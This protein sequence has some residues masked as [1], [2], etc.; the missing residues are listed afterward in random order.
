MFLQPCH[1]AF[2]VENVIA[3]QFIIDGNTGGRQHWRITSILGPCNCFIGRILIEADGAFEFLRDML[4]ATGATVAGSN[5][6]QRRAG[7]C[8]LSSF[9]AALN[10]VRQIAQ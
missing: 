5:R 2:F 6:R 7:R 8:R 9:A 10:V 3:A 4:R 1:N